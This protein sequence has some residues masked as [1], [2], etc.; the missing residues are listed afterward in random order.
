MDF[1]SVCGY[2]LIATAIYFGYSAVKFVYLQFREYYVLWNVAVGGRSDRRAISA[3][4][5]LHAYICE[6]VLLDEVSINELYTF[7]CNMIETDVTIREFHSVLLSYKYALLF[8]DRKDG[9]LRGMMLLGVDHKV[10]GRTKYTLIR[11]GL[12]LFQNYYRGGPLLYLVGS[13]HVLKELIKHPRTPL[14]IAGKAFTYKSYM[15][16]ANSFKEFYPR[17]DSPTPAFEKGIIDEFGKGIATAGE[18]YDEETCTLQR[19]RSVIK[20]FVAPISKEELENPHIR[21]FADQNP[22]WRRGHQFCVIARVRWSDVVLAV[23]KAIQRGRRA[24]GDISQRKRKGSKYSRLLSFQEERA[25]KYAVTYYEL[26]AVGDQTEVEVD[27]VH[28]DKFDEDVR[29]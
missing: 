1:W 7:C 11:L 24:R 9:S 8:R 6:S 22:G 12:S 25:S 19:E 15:V 4:I 21:F 14:Y 20:D 26:D 23:W 18:I 13:Y 10:K 28:A 5:R 16:L 3:K 2:I 27:G 29:L 17:Y